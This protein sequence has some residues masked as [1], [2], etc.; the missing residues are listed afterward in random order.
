[1]HYAYRRNENKY[2][3]CNELRNRESTPGL[4][5]SDFHLTCFRHILVGSV[6]EYPLDTR[7]TTFT[8][9]SREREAPDDLRVHTRVRVLEHGGSRRLTGRFS[10]GNRLLS[11]SCMPAWTRRE[12][13]HSAIRTTATLCIGIAE[14]FASR[15]RDIVVAEEIQAFARDTPHESKD[16]R[17]MRALRNETRT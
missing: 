13:D 3:R 6:P 11:R 4:L 16:T 1:M 2:V 9:T 12:S 15:R 7:D 5:R 10:R 14:P 8:R 17:Y